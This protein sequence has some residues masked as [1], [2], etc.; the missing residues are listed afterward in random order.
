M[1]VKELILQR[2]IKEN[3]CAAPLDEASIDIIYEYM[4]FIRSGSDL[5]RRLSDIE[6]NFE[7]ISSEAQKAI[8]DISK[9]KELISAK[10]RSL[11]DGWRSAG[12]FNDY[13]FQITEGE[14]DRI[15]S[16]YTAMIE[17]IRAYQ[18]LASVCAETI[19]ET[20]AQIR[21]C[22]ASY[23]EVYKETT[24]AVYAARLNKNVQDI[25]DCRSTLLQAHASAKESEILSARLIAAVDR[26]SRM[27]DALNKL[28]MTPLESLVTGARSRNASQVERPTKLFGAVLDTITTLE[29]I[30]IVF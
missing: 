7:Q 16:D 6:L 9:T 1:E 19:A 14:L 4:Q 20:A 17:Y 13:A 25:L 26:S 8:T 18:G 30:N 28:L 22:A 27:I 21:A 5:C 10:L 24:L 3:I 12:L 11:S 29:S 15:A 23:T 2:L